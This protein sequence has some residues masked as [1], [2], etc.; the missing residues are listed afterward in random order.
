MGNVM[1]SEKVPF[2]PKVIDASRSLDPSRIGGRAR[3]RRLLE[4]LCAGVRTCLAMVTTKAFEGDEFRAASRALSEATAQAI[5]KKRP[6]GKDHPTVA[7][8]AQ[9]RQ[10][11]QEV[12][13]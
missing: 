9:G 11:G 13:R 1:F 3:P 6:G 7:G 12:D 10:G 5:A 4:D 2:L 8:P